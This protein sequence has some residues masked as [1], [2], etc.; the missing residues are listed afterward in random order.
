MD[1]GFTKGGFGRKGQPKRFRNKKGF[2]GEVWLDTVRFC[3]NGLNLP[4]LL[5][6]KYYKSR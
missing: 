4:L 2:K 1:L 5:L 3:S 6:V